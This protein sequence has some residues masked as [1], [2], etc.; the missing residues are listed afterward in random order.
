MVVF[1]GKERGVFR[2]EQNQHVKFYYLWIGRIMAPFIFFLL[3]CCNYMHK[4]NNKKNIGNNN[5]LKAFPDWSKLMFLIT[6][7]FYNFYA[8]CKHHDVWI[9]Q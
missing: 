7:D 2:K 5:L 1:R 9:R 6:T 3:F 8:S 4:R